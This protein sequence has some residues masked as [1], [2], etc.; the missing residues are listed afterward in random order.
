MR[1]C[2]WSCPA[3]A[4]R[5]ALAPAGSLTTPPPPLAADPPRPFDFLVGGEL[6]RLSLKKHL[7]AKAVSAETVL[8]V[9]YVPA[10]LPPRPKEE[11]PHDD[12]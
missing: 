5:V 8:E 4:G 3:C 11:H 10:V 2:M 9:E 1:A 12:W 6:L 7:L